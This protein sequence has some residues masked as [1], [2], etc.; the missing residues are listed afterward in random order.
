MKKKKKIMDT[1]A[2]YLILLP[3]LL[4]FIAFVYYPFG[5]TIVTSFAN[6]TE[7]GQFMSWAGLS[8][9]KKVFTSNDFWKTTANTFYLAALCL[10]IELT[11]SM[12]LA[13][14]SIKERKGSRIYQTLFSLPMVIS[15]TA[16]ARI[17]SFALRQDGGIINTL[18]HKNW[19]LLRQEN[20]ALTVIG[21]ITCWGSIAGKYLWLMAGFR[22]VSVDLIEAA[23]IDGAGWFKRTVKILIPMASPQIFYVL[24]T[25]IIGA[26]KHFT[27]IKLLTGG[28]P[29]GS[30]TTYMWQIYKNAQI[31]TYPEVACVW[32][33]ILFVVIFIFTR[34]QFAFEE[35]MVFYQ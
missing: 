18:F 26:F 2:P 8:H 12:L 33:L 11:V 3:A 19:D 28:G 24:F 35:K 10:V 16:V 29:V 27:Q 6:T 20:T 34:I 22:N 13:L 30:T 14:T 25:S 17:W 4:L 5:K 1:I 32:S 15:A 23:T 9:W 21:I 7:I 31:L